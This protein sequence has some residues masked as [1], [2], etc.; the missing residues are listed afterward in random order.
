MYNVT[1]AGSMSR[2]FHFPLLCYNTAIG[3]KQLG[4]MLMREKTFRGDPGET[5]TERGEFF[6]LENVM[7]HL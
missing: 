3:D 6:S 2:F 4:S 5:K 1:T 7:T